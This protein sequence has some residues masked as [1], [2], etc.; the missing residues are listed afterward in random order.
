MEEQENDQEVKVG[1][2]NDWML[3]CLTQWAECGIGLSVTLTTAAGMITGV[4]ISGER[5]VARMREVL[6][7]AFEGNSRA[8]EVAAALDE[9][10]KL[11]SGEL[12]VAPSYI[13]LDHAKMMTPQGWRPTNSVTWRGKISDVHGFCL[14]TFHPASE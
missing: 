14:G 8:E 10:H 9:W 1:A 2:G 12:D 6:L 5:Y 3:Q 13:H 11:Y 4:I 7:P